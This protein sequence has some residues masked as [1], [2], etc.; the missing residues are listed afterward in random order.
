MRLSICHVITTINLGGAERQLLELA[1]S[2]KRNG[3]RVEVIFLKDQPALRHAFVDNGI[4]VNDYFSKL[5][6]IRQLISFRKKMR[7][8]TQ[9]VHAHLPRAE[10]LCALTLRKRSFLVTRHNSEPF[11]PNGSK[12]LS[13]IL[14]KFVLTRAFHT[15]FIS[16]AVE[17]YTQE[18]GELPKQ[19]S[20]SVIYYGLRNNSVKQVHRIKNKD[21]I[22][23]IATIARLVPQKN[24]PLLLDAAKIISQTG[25]NFHLTIVGIGI[26]SEEL[27]AIALKLGLKDKI[28]WLG[29]IDN[30]EKVYAD[31]DIFVL[32]SNYEGFGLV[33]LE[34][35]SFGVPIVARRISA[36]PEVLGDSHPGLVET[37]FGQDFAKTIMN[38][39]QNHDLRERYLKIQSERLS[40]FSI[41]DS[42]IN[43]YNIY[44]RLQQNA[45]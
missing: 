22:L 13:R 21:L 10:L 32:T 34:A 18:S 45:K 43:H 37:G 41:E 8:T 27:Q 2:Q 17:I 9:V 38:L 35:M 6:F 20:A 44:V 25:I 33:L 29:Q 39:S 36:I 30:V 11:F 16:K 26:L 19:A 23:R 24:I 14:S 31:M 15:I 42:E 40:K 28:T 3:S 5:N 12:Y 1:S 7:S 4:I